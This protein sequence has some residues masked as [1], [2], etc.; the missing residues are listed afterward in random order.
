MAE[1]TNELALTSQITSLSTTVHLTEDHLIKS[2]IAVEEELLSA[3]LKET[4]KE[5]EATMKE[6]QKLNFE[7]DS[8]LNE[9]AKKS[10]T[11]DIEA[12]KKV[13]ETIG[14]K[15]SKG[16]GNGEVDYHF[17]KSFDFTKK[18]ISTSVAVSIN[19]YTL[20]D[21]L[22]KEFEFPSSVN[23]IEKKVQE[24]TDKTEKLDNVLQF[25]LEERGDIAKKERRA[26][27]A[28]TMRHLGGENTHEGREFKKQMEKVKNDL[29]E[30]LNEASK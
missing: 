9:A 5:T 28:L 24:L 11:K 29:L 23:K 1:K 2:A 6:I 25:I 13:F 10:E 12:A 22:Q 20:G 15:V 27:A 18:L 26:I 19:G 7:R 21:M 16:R 3:K 8:L 4:R 30:K 14:L 17:N